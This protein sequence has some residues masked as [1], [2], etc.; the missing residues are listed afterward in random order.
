MEIPR[1]YSIAY[2]Q[3]LE[4]IKYLK[5][6]EYD[7]IPKEKIE[8][9]EEN[10]AKDYGFELDLTKELEEQITEETKAV[11]SNLFVDYIATKQDRQ[12]VLEEYNKKIFEEERKKQ[13]I[14]LNPLFENKPKPI[15][16][17]ENQT[18]LIEVKK[19]GIF[20]KIINAIKKLFKRKF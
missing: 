7:K 8:L 5:T 13:E 16:Q 12:E 20:N 15:Q 18:Q 4:I 11:I 6:E 19:E 17:E 9:Y 1:E 3:V 14:K 2:T 10:K